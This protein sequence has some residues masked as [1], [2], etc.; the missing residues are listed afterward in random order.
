[1]SAYDD[2]ISV[3]GGSIKKTEYT[4][5]AE[6]KLESGFMQ[7]GDIQIRNKYQDQTVIQVNVTGSDNGVDG[8]HEIWKDSTPLSIYR[9][10]QGHKGADT[11]AMITIRK[12][13]PGEVPPPPP[14]P[15]PGKKIDWGLIGYAVIGIVLLVIAFYLLYIISRK[16]GP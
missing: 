5:H 11:I 10:W 1:M 12:P 2:C 4:D 7:D 9:F 16:G 6:V 15:S 14:P 3:I 13:D 8:Q